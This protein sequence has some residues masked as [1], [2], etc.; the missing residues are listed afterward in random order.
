MEQF[1]LAST[2]VFVW[3]VSPDSD[4]IIVV[5]KSFAHSYKKALFVALGVSIATVFHVIYITLALEFIVSK[6]L[7]IKYIG[8][9]Y[10]IYI[11]ALGLFAKKSDIFLTL[12]DKPN[13]I[14]NFEAIR[15]GFVND[16]LNSNTILFLIGLFSIFIGHE[17]SQWELSLYIAMIFFQSFIWYGFVAYC[18]SRKIVREKFS[19][20]GHWIDRITGAILITCG[21]Q[22]LM[23]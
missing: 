20:F 10:L 17:I 19:T 12:G 15:M 2:L 16:A 11:G 1:I 5:K 7:I 9:T 13:E 6:I 8:V 18:F 21:V 22:I 3:L 23:N 4:F 14:S